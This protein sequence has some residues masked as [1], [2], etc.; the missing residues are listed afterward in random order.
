[1]QRPTS[2]IISTTSLPLSSQGP[3]ST[4]K[5]A[6]SVRADRP[7]PPGCGVFYWEVSILARGRDGFIGVGLAGPDVK[8][9]RLPGWDAGSFGYH[10]DDGHA[11]RGS[12]AGRPYGPGFGAGDVVGVLLNRAERTISFTKNG[13]DLGVAFWD[14]PADAALHPT[15][16]MRT[17]DEEVEANFG[18][19]P[20]RGAD[21]GALVAAAAARAAGRVA[22]VALPPAGPGLARAPGEPPPPLA[23]LAA[24]AAAAGGADRAGASAAA[25]ALDYCRHVGAHRAAAA[26]ATSLAAAAAAAGA[27]VGS[28]GSAAGPT[29]GADSAAAAAAT[30]SPTTATKSGASSIAAALTAAAAVAA[31]PSAGPR[32]AVRAALEGGQVAAAR[33]AAEAVAPGALEAVPAVAFAL[34]VQAFVELVRAGDDGAA[35]AFGRSV[36]GRAL[37]SGGAAASPAGPPLGGSTP[38]PPPALDPASR[39]LLQDALSLLAYADPA[40]SPCGGLLAQ[41]ARTALADRVDA[42]L[43]SAAGLPPAPAL[44]VAIRQAGAVWG[45]L[46]ELGDADA[47]LVSPAGL[48]GLSGGGG[49]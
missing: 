12:G 45:A 37:A 18:G 31:D 3:G 2:L 22:G 4:D 20:W 13:V 35:M 38:A 21:V 41:A 30:A 9:E 49:G 10:G 1:M 7:A 42:L 15:V 43:R 46:K 32:A 29:A 11:F 8:L 40:A 19:A 25:L 16:G 17:P 26:L 33:A 34:D 23:A 48:L 5:D 24:A 14:V 6:A 27:G 39:E 36:L 28:G 44:E 47:A